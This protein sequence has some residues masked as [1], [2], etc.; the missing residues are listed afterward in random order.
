MFKSW[1]LHN[2][3]SH[4]KSILNFVPGINIII[5]ASDKGKSA[6][7]RGFYWLY[8]NRPLGTSF[9]SRWATEKDDCSFIITTMEDKVISR[10]RN[11]DF[12]GYTIDDEKF[13]AMGKN[14]PEDV[15]KALNITELNISKQEESSFLISQSSGEIA[16]FLNK[17]VKLDV[18]D[19][20][21]TLVESWKRKSNQ[22]L[23]RLNKEISSQEKEYEQYHWVD[24]AKEIID[25]I[26]KLEL[27]IEDK[28][29]DKKF[30]ISTKDRYINL[31]KDIDYFNPIKEKAGKLLIDIS[32]LT[33]S[34]KGKQEILTNLNNQFNIFKDIQNKLKNSVDF[35]LISSK[36]DIL[37]K[38]F[39]VLEEIKNKKNELQRSINSYSNIKKENEQLKKDIEELVIKLP[40]VCPTCGREL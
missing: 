26:E 11:K 36:L 25:S 5:G 39:L 6:I 18:I 40:K 23:N 20:M 30:L 29:I 32:Q 2:F 19:I 15:I 1:E 34:I 14:V 13:E 33:S 38:R 21:F 35:S 24:K 16:K 12:N 10:I 8:E 7:F 17:I 9:I 37:K 4:T 22:E 28:I 27:I 31:Q 3:Q